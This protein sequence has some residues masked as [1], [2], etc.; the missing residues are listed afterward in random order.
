MARPT[1][2]WSTG[3][4]WPASPARVRTWRKPGGALRRRCRSSTATVNAS[5]YERYRPVRTAHM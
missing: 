1:P 5:S 2:R 3:P 4:H